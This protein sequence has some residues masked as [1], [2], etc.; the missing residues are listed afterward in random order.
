MAKHPTKQSYRQA[1]VVV[2]AATVQIPLP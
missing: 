2:N 1:L